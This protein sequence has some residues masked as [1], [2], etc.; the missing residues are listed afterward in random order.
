M[1]SYLPRPQWPKATQP[2]PYQLALPHL[3]LSTSPEKSLP[4]KQ[5]P[6]PSFFRSPPPGSLKDRRQ[7]P[8]LAV[9]R[10]ERAIA[11]QHSPGRTPSHP[12][13]PSNNPPCWKS[14]VFGQREVLSIS[15]W[16]YA[17]ATYIAVLSQSHPELV[18]GRLAYM[19]NVFWEATRF[20]DDGWRTYDYVFRSQSAADT[21]ADCSTTNPSLMVVYMQSGTQPAR[22]SCPLCHESDHYSSP[23]VR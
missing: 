2:M 23:R 11:G 13:T 4:P 15:S 7:D 16:A 18:V 1:S 22:P 17:F 21:S 14:A 9:R 6:C 20:G 8:I 5:R 10:D 3:R 19:R 12:P